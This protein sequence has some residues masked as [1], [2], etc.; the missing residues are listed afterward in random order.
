MAHLGKTARKSFDA[1][2][3]ARAWHEAAGDGEP[4]PEALA[5]VAALWA[6]AHSGWDLESVAGACYSA[7]RLSHTRSERLAGACL[8]GLAL[9]T[10]AADGLEV[11]RL[12]G[13]RA[14]AER[15]NVRPPES[16]ALIVGAVYELD[17]GRVR[18][19][20]D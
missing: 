2:A 13:L 18:V 19:L 8:F 16:R 15:E 17:T 1:T 6:V 3:S 12:A 4:G 11:E 10:A 14:L 7:A 9:A 20:E 5:G